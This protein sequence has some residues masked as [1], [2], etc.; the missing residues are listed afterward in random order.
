MEGMEP[1]GAPQH[2]DDTPPAGARSGPIEHH[3]ASK[4]PTMLTVIAASPLR[5]S[6]IDSADGV[7]RLFL[8]QAAGLAKL[9]DAELA[10]HEE[11]AE[12]VIADLQR[13]R[14]LIKDDRHRRASD[15]QR[16]LAD[17]RVK[18]LAEKARLDQEI[19]E[20][21]AALESLHAPSSE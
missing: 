11:A 10:A 6:T 13:Q 9:S 1:P 7:S 4:V 19:D 20:I 14:L 8:Y 15:R 2:G 18:K 12:H 21:D 3:P 16:R 17:E 5:G